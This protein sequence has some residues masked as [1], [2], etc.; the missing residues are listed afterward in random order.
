MLKTEVAEGEGERSLGS[1]D[2]MLA[3]LSSPVNLMDLLHLKC[4]GNRTLDQIELSQVC[5]GVSM[6]L[7]LNLGIAISW[8]CTQGQVLVF[9]E[10]ESISHM[11]RAGYSVTDAVRPKQEHSDRVSADK[12][13][14]TL[15]TFR[16]TQ[17]PLSWLICMVAI[18][19]PITS[20]TSL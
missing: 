13:V 18:S 14:N 5:T 9:C 7:L 20:L 19:L 4:R 1:W 17:C 6:V 16:M 12:N 11:N 2:L 10:K 3:S 15:Q 8:P